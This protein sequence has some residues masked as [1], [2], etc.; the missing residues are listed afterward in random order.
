MHIRA[1]RK[2]D[3]ATLHSF[4]PVF[5]CMCSV[6]VRKGFQINEFA[7]YDVFRRVWLHFPR[8]PASNI[9]DL[10]K[11]CVG[12]I[13]FRIIPDNLTISLSIGRNPLFEKSCN[14][15]RSS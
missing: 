10:P 3:W 1:Q 7:F 8:E 13:I 2:P 14:N 15:E 4:V 5:V 12:I 11:L 9:T 6:F